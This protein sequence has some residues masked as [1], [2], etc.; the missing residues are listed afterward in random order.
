V[1]DETLDV[2]L[3]TQSRHLEKGLSLS[4]APKVKGLPQKIDLTLVLVL[5]VD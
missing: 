5:I 4:A 1:E 3:F 2:T